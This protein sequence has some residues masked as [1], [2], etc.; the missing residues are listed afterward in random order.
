MVH[1]EASAADCRALAVQFLETCHRTGREPLEIASRLG[2]LA[3]SGDRATA[4]AATQ[5]IFSQIVEYLGDCFQP[6]LCDLYVRFFSRIIEDCRRLPEGRRIDRLLDEFGL[7]NEEAIRERAARLSSAGT[8]EMSWVRSV[9]KAL[10]LSRVTLGADVAVTSVIVGKLKR[11]C[12]EAE[13]VLLGGPKASSLFASDPR[14]RGAGVAYARHGVLLERLGAW[15]SLVSLVASETARLR[16]EEYLVVDTDSRLTQLGLLPVVADASRY[17][18]FESRRFGARRE[19]SIAELA[20]EWAAGVFGDDGETAYPYVGL[21]REDREG[22]EALR[23]HLGTRSLASLNLGV[24]GNSAKRVADPFERNLLLMLIAEGYCIV[25]DRGAGDEE[26]ERTAGLVGDLEARGKSVHWL[27]HGMAEAAADVYV[28]E[29]SLSGFA[30]LIAV[31]DLYA[32][33]DS[34]GGHLAAA[35]GVRGIDIFSGAVSPRMLERW[36]PWGRWPAEVVAVE[37]NTRAG[38]VL[39]AVRERLP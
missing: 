4:V 34:A 27:R 16:A 13:I 15:T 26:L 1:G 17:C 35:L 38:L 36:R 9:R 14:V 21:A 10:V 25:L 3:A 2:A 37:D 11:A 30:G 33:Y 22:G 20:G 32:G 5:A 28:W 12:P 6:E 18:F 31:S 23:R 24:G 29:G 39:E 19:S 8:L 7:G